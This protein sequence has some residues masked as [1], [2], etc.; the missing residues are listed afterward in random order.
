M[1]FVLTLY[2]KTIQIW[3]NVHVLD[4]FFELGL[5]LFRN[6][7]LKS[8]GRLVYLKVYHCKQSTLY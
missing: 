2:L 1:T 8:L 7:Y 4:I 5:S 6:L 3:K